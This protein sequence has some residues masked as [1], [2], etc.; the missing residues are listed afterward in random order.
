MAEFDHMNDDDD[1]NADSY[2]LKTFTSL[3][4]SS[5]E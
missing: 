5:L 4:K 3:T 2:S 1:P